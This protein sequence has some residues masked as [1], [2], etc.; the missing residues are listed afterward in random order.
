MVGMRSLLKRMKL[1][2]QFKRPY[3]ESGLL[4]NYGRQ[5]SRQIAGG[6]QEESSLNYTLEDSTDCVKI[7]TDVFGKDLVFDL[8]GLLI[9]KEG[10]NMRNTLMHGLLDDDELFAP[11][12]V[13]LYWLTLH[14]IFI[15]V[16]NMARIPQ[17]AETASAA[18]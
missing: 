14:I 15:P 4:N 6:I 5:T 9:K 16:K 2:N 7:L 3:P 10:G 1:S 13:Y 11:E 12:V 17:N 8:Q 18:E